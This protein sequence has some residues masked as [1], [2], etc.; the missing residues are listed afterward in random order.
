MGKT[1]LVTYQFHHHYAVSGYNRLAE[2][3]PCSRIRIP[4]A[5]A[6][7]LRR[8]LTYDQIQSLKGLTGLTGYFP[9]CRWLE[10]QVRLLARLRGD[11]VFHFIYPENSFFFSAQHK[12]SRSV[13]FVATYHQP[14][15]ESRN[16]ILKTDAIRT[17]D[18]VILLSESQR[19]FFEP[20]VGPDRIFVVPHGVDLSFF[21][22]SRQR[23]KERR[24]IAVGNWLRDF[25]TLA[26]ALRILSDIHPD[27]VCDVVTLRENAVHF[28]GLKNVVFHSGIS[29]SALR[30]M[31]Q[32]S[33]LAVLA[34]SGA[35]ANN[36]LLEAQASGLPIVA[37]DLPAVR[38][39]TTEEGCRYVPRSDPG[40]LAATIDSVLHDAD[41][42]PG[43]GTANRVNAQ[44]YSWESIGLKT[45]DVYRAIS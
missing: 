1:Y 31:Y 44:K 16:F 8:S 43:M 20:L 23:S 27:V 11:A 26:S 24:I 7:L 12:K 9:E 3:V 33:I 41:S 34:L 22:P 4:S 25:T 39:Y 13:R 42:L 18:A 5:V 35:A 21:S 40:S 17:L 36:A 37:T 32:N 14:V 28:D 6:Q 15:Q 2:F 10:W 19:E 38:E 45:M 30:A 29:D